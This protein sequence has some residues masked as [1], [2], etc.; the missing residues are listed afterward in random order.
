MPSRSIFCV[1]LCALLAGCGSSS[2]SSSSAQSGAA[3][4]PAPPSLVGVYTTKLTKRDLTRNRAPELQEA[5]GWT[6][7]ISNSG[8]SSGGH[9]LTIANV[10]AGALEAPE[11]VVTDHRI[12]LKHEECAAGGATHFYDNEYRFAQAGTTLRFTKLL[13]SCPDRIAET[14]L[15]SEPWKK[16]GG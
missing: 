5:P 2:K 8:G 15:T 7:T 10:K 6:L 13:N 11:F 1:A 4:G 16:Q 9:A 3:D 12:L 14:V